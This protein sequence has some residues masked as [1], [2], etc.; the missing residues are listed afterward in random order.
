[1]EKHIENLKLLCR[2]CGEKNQ[3]T[4]NVADFKQV[5]AFSQ[6]HYLFEISLNFLLGL[7]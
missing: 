1:M 2:L 3:I 7:N 4:K 5:C 6:F